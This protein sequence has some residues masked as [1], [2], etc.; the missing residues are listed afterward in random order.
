MNI[1]IF[2]LVIRENSWRRP[3]TRCV[4]MG[5]LTCILPRS[6][7]SNHVIFEAELSA[8]KSVSAA[9]SQRRLPRREHRYAR[10]MTPQW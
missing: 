4:A 7:R 3:T 1:D 6:F 9:S 8:V 2:I 5:D 10:P